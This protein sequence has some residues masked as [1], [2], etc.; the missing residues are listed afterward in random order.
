MKFKNVEFITD[1]KNWSEWEMTSN[2]KMSRNEH[3]FNLT[4]MNNK[5]SFSDSRYFEGKRLY[6]HK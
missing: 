5:K 2:H 6:D 3:S 1:N 4:K